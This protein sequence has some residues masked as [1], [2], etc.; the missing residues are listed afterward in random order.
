MKVIIPTGPG[1]VL[2]DTHLLSSGIFPG[3]Y[4]SLPK[5]VRLRRDVYVSINIRSWPAW[6]QG[7]GNEKFTSSGDHTRAQDKRYPGGSQDHAEG[8]PE[9]EGARRARGHSCMDRGEGSLGGT[10]RHSDEEALGTLPEGRHD[11]EA[12]G[13]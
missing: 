5:V 3:P 1:N 9:E 4:L 8:S 13:T 10:G 11:E 2:L 12:I 7:D 6:V